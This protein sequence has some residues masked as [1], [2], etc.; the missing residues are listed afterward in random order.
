[1]AAAHVASIPRRPGVGETYDA[2]DAEQ[3]QAVEA[4]LVA[5]KKRVRS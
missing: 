5:A 4:A 2:L 3:R 1:M